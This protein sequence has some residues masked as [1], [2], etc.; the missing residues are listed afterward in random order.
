MYLK[1]NRTGQ[2]IEGH[3][4]D[5]NK[6]YFLKALQDYDKQLYIQWNPYKCKGW[7]C[8]E[9]RRTPNEKI[10]YPIAKGYQAVD[11]V[12]L[13]LTSHVLDCAFLNY[14]QLRKVQSMDVWNKKHWIND[15]EYLEDKKKEEG[16]EKAQKNLSYNVKQERKAWKDMM[17]AVRSGQSPAQILSQ[18]KWTQE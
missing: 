14:D 3:V 11:Y 13:N 7:G 18:V 16:L 6:E 5:C 10:V 9:I 2:V 12:E 15:L 1:A 17:E 8:W 4:L